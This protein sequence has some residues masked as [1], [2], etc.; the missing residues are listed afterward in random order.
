MPLQCRW[1]SSAWYEGF[2][3]TQ[4]SAGV[5]SADH[6]HIQHRTAFAHNRF[7]SSVTLRIVHITGRGRE[8]RSASYDRADPLGDIRGDGPL[9][10]FV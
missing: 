5:L 4:S 2:T 8:L 6:D 10:R 3:F 1:A 7:R 9:N